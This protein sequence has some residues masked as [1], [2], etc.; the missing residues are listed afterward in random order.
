MRANRRR[1]SQQFRST[2]GGILPGGAAEGR[3]MGMV[4]VTRSAVLGPPECL[5][6]VAQRRL[7]RG[8]GDEGGEDC[9]LVAA[10]RAWL[11]R[12]YP[13][14]DAAVLLGC[15]ERG[16]RP[17]LARLLRRACCG[18]PLGVPDRVHLINAGGRPPT[19][20]A[21]PVGRLPRLAGNT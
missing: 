8:F 1:L 7:R 9:D 6:G 13:G 18:M 19:R 14:R 15:G 12:G 20:A 4:A 2:A 11:D 5:A 21:G 17:C 3:W 16:Q 10:V